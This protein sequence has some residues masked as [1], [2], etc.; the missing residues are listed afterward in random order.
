MNSIILLPSLKRP[1]LVKRFFE[2]YHKTKGS[3]AGLL[4]VDKTDLCLNDYRALQLPQ[5][6]ELVETE[7][8]TMGDKIE[9]V[10]TRWIDL[11]AVAILNDDHIPMTE[12]WDAK[13]F[14]QIKGY[15]IVSTN[16]GM[17]FPHRICGMIAVSGKII[18]E[19]GWFFP[20]GV[21]HLFTDDAWEVLA[22]T[23]CL[24][25]L[26][27]VMVK[28]DHA[29][30]HKNEDNTHKEVYAEESWKRD[31]EAFD[32]WL[33]NDAQ[34]DVQKVLNMQPKQG[35]M[36]A[37]PS[38]DKN[39]AFG[40]AVGMFDLGIAFAQMNQH[41]E[42]G[43]VEGSSLIPH[44][45]NSL[46]HMFL[47]SK[48][49]KLLF[50]D[51]DQSFSRNDVLHLYNSNKLL[52]SGITP[53][54]RFPINFNFEPLPEHAS[55]FKDTTNKSVEELVK[56]AQEKCDPKGEIEVNRA[57]TGFMMIDRKVFEIMKDHVG[58]YLA[59][60][61]GSDEEHYEFFKMGGMDGKYRGEDWY[62]TELAKKLKIPI[63]I[64]ANAI[65][66]HQG[67]YIWDPK[68]IG[69]MIDIRVAQ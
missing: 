57:G 37:T 34:K 46:V 20:K 4:L 19:L 9:E 17:K 40:Y 38:H 30:I 24:Q 13:V 52:I 23:G 11:D 68:Q 12:E 15:N 10:K 22:R 64:N 61:G 5:G 48:C 55:Y 51:S 47:K 56:F 14:A 26:P 31:K 8:I 69:G 28:H 42:L 58:K 44:A 63:H 2:A 27:D 53:H 39:V 16:D 41:L 62:F 29:F 66:A 45:R 49:Q 3:A 35:I 60:D 67:T 33:Q 7:G 50:I 18:R 1:A 59:F 21:K 36:V 6:W 65:V 32:K 54:K 43:R 25:V